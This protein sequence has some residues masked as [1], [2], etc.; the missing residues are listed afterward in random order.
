ML[1]QRQ[2]D[3]LR[4]AFRERALLCTAEAA[5]RLPHASG[6]QPVGEVNLDTCRRIAGQVRLDLRDVEWFALANRI[7]P[8]RY[9]RN[10][11]SLGIEGQMRLLASRAAVIGLGGLGGNVCEQL[12][13][14]GVGRIIGVD[15]D[16]F[17]ETNLNR[18]TFADT[19]SLGRG[20]AAETARRLSAINPGS[21]LDH[22]PV[23]FG[24]LPH[25]T[26]HECDA[27]FDCLDSIEARLELAETCASAGVP[28]VH[29]A[30]AGWYGQVAVV[31]PGSDLLRTVY[32]DCTAGIESATGN[33]PFTAAVAASLMVAEAIKVM[34]GRAGPGAPEILVFDLLESEWQVLRP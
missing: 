26:L 14:A 12:A 23:P 18:Q 30:I 3:R 22:R 6:A 13:R 20:K 33:P 10:I 19:Q 32:R 4:E 21:E 11:G 29:G 1:T 27:V 25:G 15:P 24:E 8:Q 9:D 2:E 31:W 16:A 17:D 28:L 7:V 34:T 5:P